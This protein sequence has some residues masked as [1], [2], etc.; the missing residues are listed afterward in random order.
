MP[1]E[2]PK[3]IARSSPILIP[4]HKYSPVVSVNPIISPIAKAPPAPYLAPFQNP[5]LFNLTD[6]ISLTGI[7]FDLLPL[8]QKSV[9]RCRKKPDS[10]NW[11]KLYSSLKTRS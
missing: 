10:P 8:N 7:S 2:M 3:G 11:L 4:S 1:V 5:L 9:R 6:L